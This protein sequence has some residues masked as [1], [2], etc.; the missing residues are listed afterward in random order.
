MICAFP[1]PGAF[2][3]IEVR[4][5]GREVRIEKDGKSMICAFLT[6]RSLGANP[7]GTDESF[8]QNQP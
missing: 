5:Q 7:F 2:L 4:M 1:T 6:P 3:L 8:Y